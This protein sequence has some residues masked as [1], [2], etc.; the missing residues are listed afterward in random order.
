M[1]VEIG[2]S[3]DGFAPLPEAVGVA[4]QAVAAG[5]TSLWMAEHLGYRE[6]IVSC[7]AY[8]LAT[9]RAQVVPTAVSPYVMHPVP[10]AMALATIAEAAPG[11]VS[12]AVGIGNPLFLEEAGVRV[13]KPVRAV[14]EFVEALRALWTGEPVHQDALLF[15][16]AGARLAFRPPAPIPIYLA[17]MKPQMLRL[18]G[19]LAEGV[20]L[21]AGLSPGFVAHSLGLAAAG[22]RES[23][24]DPAT[25]RRS[26]YVFFL[27]SRDERRAVATVRQKLAFLF[28][29]RF[30]DDN[31]AHSGL[32]STR[33]RSSPPS[34][35]GTSRRRPAW[36]PTRRWRHS[37]PAGPRRA[38]GTGSR[39]TWPPV[40][41][42]RCWSCWARPRTARSAWTWSA[43]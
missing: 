30:I 41:T 28:R 4:R 11:R 22:A 27:A 35:G 24:R 23:G 9:E 36:S 34:A 43:T 33:P 37:P 39:P 40:S 6:A 13:D 7:L 3:F 21:S 20:S 16:L 10:T 17:P 18:A 42:S 25:L 2:V 12:L 19:R 29:N 1:A 32:P 15:R 31:L 14:R 26:G 8:A 5:A 38:A